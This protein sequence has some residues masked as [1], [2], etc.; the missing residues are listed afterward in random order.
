MIYISPHHDSVRPVEAGG[1]VAGDLSLSA[2]R[3]VEAG[4]PEKDRFGLW[5][6]LNRKSGL[7]TR[8]LDSVP[9]ILRSDLAL[10]AGLTFGYINLK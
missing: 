9:G 6:A 5:V 3:P 10:L 8:D 4:G 1:L 2:V 7:V